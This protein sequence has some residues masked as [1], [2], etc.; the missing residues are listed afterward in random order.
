MKPKA[1]YNYLAT[2]AHIVA[3]LSAGTKVNVCATDDFTKSVHA[4]LY[5]IDP[6]NQK[7]KIPFFRYAF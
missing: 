5:Y 2:V 1:G 4:L 6:G 7:R 3:E